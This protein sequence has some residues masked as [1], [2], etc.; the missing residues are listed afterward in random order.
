MVA[1]CS[2]TGYYYLESDLP[3]DFVN[4]IRHSLRQ[5]TEHK[6]V[7]NNVNT[8]ITTK[9]PTLAVPILR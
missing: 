6:F 9:D 4:A 8:I 1:G 7:R 5:K 2:N 3:R